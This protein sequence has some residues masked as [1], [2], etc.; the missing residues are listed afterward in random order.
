MYRSYLDIEFYPHEKPEADGEIVLRD[1]KA[2]SQQRYCDTSADN[3]F[4]Y[5]IE[6]QFSCYLSGGN[7]F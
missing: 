3:F 6:V 4:K 7:S 2:Y 1:L 5:Q